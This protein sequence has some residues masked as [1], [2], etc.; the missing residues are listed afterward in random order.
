MSDPIG[1]DDNDE[2]LLARGIVYYLMV[3]AILLLGAGLVRA[4]LILGITPTGE[5]FE[6]MNLS[7]RTGVVVLVFLDLFA[8]VGLWIRAIWGPL[9]WAVAIIVETAMYTLLSDLFGAHPARVAVHFVLIG[10]YLVL[11]AAQWWRAAR[12]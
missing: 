2:D 3:V 8:A 9:M 7:A 1:I 10:I 11:A 6:T 12:L 4:G 5:S